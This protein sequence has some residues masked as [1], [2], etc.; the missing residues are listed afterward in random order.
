[1]E[2][3]CQG[4]IRTATF[5]PTPRRAGMGA[6]TDIFRAGRWESLVNFEHETENTIHPGGRGRKQS[7]LTPEQAREVAEL[8]L[9]AA[10]DAD[11]RT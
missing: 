7:F 10:E 3:P 5:C 8:L 2:R 9:K 11:A 6:S 4:E 1:M